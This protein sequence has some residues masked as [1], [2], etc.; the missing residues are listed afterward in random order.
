MDAQHASDIEAKQQ[1]IDE[2]ERR[3]PI[4]N[5]NAAESA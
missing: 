3:D 5:E 2:L 1:R 4:L